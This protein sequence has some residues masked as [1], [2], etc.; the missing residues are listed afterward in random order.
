MQLELNIIRQMLGLPAIAGVDA[1]ASGY[2]IDSRTIQPGEIFFAIHGER[3]DGHAFVQQVLQNGAVA[4]VVA[5]SHV[6]QLAHLP[7]HQLLVVESTLDALQLL[8]RQMRQRWHGLVIGVTGSVGKTTTKE[9]I[10]R[11]LSSSSRWVL[12]S[13]GNLNNGYGMP[14]QLLK[15]EPHHSMAVLEMGMSSAGEIAALAAIAQPDWGVVTVVAPVHTE[16]FPDGIEGVARAKRELVEALPA[17]G[18]AFLNADDPRVAGFAAHTAARVVTF[19]RAESADVRATRV[20]QL[21]AEGTAF[22]IESAGQQAECRLRLVGAHNVT[23][24]LAAAAVGLAAGLTLAECAAALDEMRPPDSRGQTLT[25][26]GAYLINDCYNSNPLALDAMVTTLAGIAAARRIVVA[27]EMLELGPESEQL[28]AACGRH[29]AG[30]GIEVLIGVR[31]QAEAMVAAAQAAGMQAIFV[32]TPL[33]AGDWLAANLRP[34]D[35]VLLKASRGVKLELALER[36]V[37]RL[38]ENAAAK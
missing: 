13:H 4:A 27:G 33:E 25:L 34:Q 23:N 2:S 8:A 15:V 1:V 21:G 16:Y 11:V 20:Q 10:A 9:A 26:A 38:R 36:L 12:K 6:G 35:A 14:L 28:H 29:A 19:G 37:E 3:F 32:A 24:A 18:I 31:G 22:T 17:T 5:K 30:Q 7:Q